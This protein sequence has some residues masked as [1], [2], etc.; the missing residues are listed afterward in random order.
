MQYLGCTGVHLHHCPSPHQ[1]WSHQE[2]LLAQRRHPLPS[3]EPAQQAWL[4]PY[5]RH[6]CCDTRLLQHALLAQRLASQ[7]QYQTAW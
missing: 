2:Q 1:T 3:L 4:V 6:A 7:D 5:L